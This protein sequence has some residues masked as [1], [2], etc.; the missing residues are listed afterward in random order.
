MQSKLIL[1]Y[2]W[3]PQQPELGTGFSGTGV[4]DNGEPTQL[5]AVN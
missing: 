5:W 2:A 1:N 4:I 3:Y